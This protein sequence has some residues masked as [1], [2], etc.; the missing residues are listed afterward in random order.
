M[1]GRVRLII[2]LSSEKG[3]MRMTDRA[4]KDLGLLAKGMFDVQVRSDVGRK[5]HDL[6]VTA[7]IKET[8]VDMETALLVY[9]AR[10]TPLLATT[11][12]SH[13]AQSLFGDAQAGHMLACKP[14]GHKPRPT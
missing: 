11:P 4:R 7:I 8:G 3:T 1:K 5:M 10:T 2:T 9:R 12:S 13:L 6:G 14:A